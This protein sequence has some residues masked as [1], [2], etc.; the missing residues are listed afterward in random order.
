MHDAPST[1]P[2]GRL[3][4]READI[5]SELFAAHAPVRAAYV[6]G[7]AAT[8]RRN[9]R[10]DLDVA[11]W[12]RDDANARTTKLDLLADLTRQGFDEI[13]LV[14][15]NEADLV[16]Q[17]EAIRPNRLVYAADDYE[18]GRVFSLV[19]RKYWDFLPYLEVQRAAYKQRLERG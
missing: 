5:L 17:Y 3:T 8:G 1:S 16:M 15:L 4:S 6:F 19:L 2:T 10:S 7:S 14:I 12:L 11:V 18:H 13:D 9:T